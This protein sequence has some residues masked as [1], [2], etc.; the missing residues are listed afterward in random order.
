[1]NFHRLFSFLEIEIISIVNFMCLVPEMNVQHFD[2]NEKLQINAH[3]H[4]RE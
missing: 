4:A 1:M 3:V 2:L